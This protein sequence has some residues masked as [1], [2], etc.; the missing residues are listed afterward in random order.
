MLI[1]VHIHIFSRCGVVVKY[2]SFAYSAT[3]KLYA[4]T[5]R[6]RILVLQIPAPRGTRKLIPKRHSDQLEAKLKLE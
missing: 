5:P 2:R 6:L 3:F 1:D 4:K